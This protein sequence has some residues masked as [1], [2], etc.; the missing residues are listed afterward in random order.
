[1]AARRLVRRPEFAK[2]LKKLRDVQGRGVIL[3]KLD[4]FILGK[5]CDLWPIGE[6]VYELR[7]H[8]GPGY[9]IYYKEVGREHVL[10][11]AGTK[12]TQDRDIAKAKKFAREL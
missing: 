5:P 12:K 10:L 2:W 4:D 8:F 3:G 6:K 9:R 1:V 7:I 11:W